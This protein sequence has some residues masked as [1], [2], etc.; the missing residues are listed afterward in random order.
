MNDTSRQQHLPKPLISTELSAWL[1]LS[2]FFVASLVVL[3]FLGQVTWANYNAAMR[4][5]DGA[6]LRS[7]VT[8]GVLYQEPR[9]LSSRTLERLPDS[10]DPC[11][12]EKDICLPLKPGYRIKTMPAAGYGPVA[13][14]VLPDATHIQLW[15][16]DSGTDIVY[17]S[18]QV[19]RWTNQKQ[20]VNVT[21][22]AGYAR[23]DLAE[24]QPYTVVEYSVTLPD[25]YKVWMTPGGSYSIRV[26][27]ASNTP[28]QD[29]SARIEI[30][31]RAG[32]ATVTHAGQTVSLAERQMVMMNSDEGIPD[33]QAATWQIVRDPEWSGIKARKDTPDA[34]S[35][36]ESYA[37]LGSPTMSAAERNGT[38]TV[39]QGCNPKTPD[40]CK[41]DKQLQV[42]RISRTGIQTHDYAV[43]VAQYMDADV[44]EFTSLRLTAWVRLLAQQSASERTDGASCPVK[45]QLVYKFISPDDQ[46]QERTICLYPTTGKDIGQQESGQ[47]LYRALPLYQ[48][49]KLDIDLREDEYLKLARYIQ[50]IRIEAEGLNYLAEITD[51][52]LTGRQ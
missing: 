35:E 20:V 14:M 22:N 4:T 17:S 18:Y 50:V 41:T 37:R 1:V 49:Y 23:Y 45:F 27:P 51:L 39:V 34:P 6:Q 3:V 48:W 9:S 42:L 30:A 7:H 38:V 36:W 2:V 5:L 31:V 10:L 15:A 43:G 16:Q 46:Q 8:T 24:F 44:S 13:S 21:Q 29:T 47:T 19:S 11:A 26:I 12:G 40:F 33:P 28:V 52:S 32:S 25:G